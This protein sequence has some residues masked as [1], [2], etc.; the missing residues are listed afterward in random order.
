MPIRQ[1][2]MP[3]AREKASLSSNISVVRDAAEN[4][5]EFTQILDCLSRYFVK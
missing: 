3:D 4:S 1:D 5:F 2:A